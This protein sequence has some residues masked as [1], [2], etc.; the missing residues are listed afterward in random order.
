MF[1]EIA[2]RQS[3]VGGCIF[4]LEKPGGGHSIDRTRLPLAAPI[5]GVRPWPNGGKRHALGAWYRKYLRRVAFALSRFKIGRTVIHHGK[6]KELAV[7]AGF[8]GH[9]WFQS[10]NRSG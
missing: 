2:H 1:L 7:R 9:L 3:A 5:V 4:Q 8:F 6:T 10:S